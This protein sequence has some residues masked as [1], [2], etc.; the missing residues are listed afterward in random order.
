MS[1][2]SASVVKLI[3]VRKARPLRPLWDRFWEK[4]DTTGGTEACW[5]WMG[6]ISY[7][8][9][10]RKHRGK[11]AKRWGRGVIQLAGR[12][13]RT[14][15]AHRLALCFTGEGLD[16]YGRPEHAAHICNNR[17][18]CNPVHLYWATEQQNFEDRYGRASDR[19]GTDTER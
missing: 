13:S 10:R 4:V 9:R 17:L 3:E 1:G 18:C 16:E 19:N 11:F 7:T 14:L 2:L 6:A 8:K 5:P 12:G 15:K